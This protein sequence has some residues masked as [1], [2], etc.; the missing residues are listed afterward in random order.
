M[1]RIFSFYHSYLP[2]LFRGHYEAENKNKPAFEEF[3]TASLTFGF[4]PHGKHGKIVKLLT[5]T[6][7]TQILT[8]IAEKI[9][10]H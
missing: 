6:H 9:R 5:L 8:L 7:P 2:C 10:G 3:A 1:G 4:Y